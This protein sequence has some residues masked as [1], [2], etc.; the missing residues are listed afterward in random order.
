MKNVLFA[1]TALVGFAGVAF[2]QDTGVSL[3]GSAEMG[4]TYIDIDGVGDEAVFHNDIDVT[5]TLSGA[6]DNGLTFGATIDLDE[7]GDG[8]NL[9]FENSVFVSGA[10]GTLSMGDIDGAYDRALSN[11]HAG[12]LSDEA[13]VASGTTGFDGLAPEILRY[14]YAFGPVVLSA[15]LGLEDQMPINDEAGGTSNGDLT[16]NVYGLGI[17]YGGDFGAMTLDLGAGIQYTELS[18]EEAMVY[19]G[20]ATLGF[21]NFEVIGVVEVFDTDSASASATDGES[22]GIS[23]A[24]MTG[25]WEFA[26][27]Y[28][29]SDF[30]GDADVVQGYV[31]YDLGGGAEIVSAASW[32]DAGGVETTRAGFGLGFS[33]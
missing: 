16:E 28:E 7:V 29:H 20:S 26:L 19:G 31:T 27:G 25:P 15:S 1:T 30:G 14:D 32:V 2:A 6:T 21:G 18:N 23:G 9:D 10:F 13:D 11:I 12:G 3:S 4:I 17:A 8:D 22:F 24:Y 5:F 33:F